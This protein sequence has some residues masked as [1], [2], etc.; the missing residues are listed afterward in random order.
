[1]A[2]FIADTRKIKAPTPLSQSDAKLFSIHSSTRLMTLT[3]FATIKK[4]SA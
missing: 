2:G 3:K 4:K 1:M